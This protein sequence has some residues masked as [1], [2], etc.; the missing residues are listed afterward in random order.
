MFPLSELELDNDPC[1]VCNL[2]LEI[3]Q[4]SGAQL[5]FNCTST[6]LADVTVAEPFLQYRCTDFF[7]CFSTPRPLAAKWT[8]MLLLGTALLFCA[9]M[10]IEDKAVGLTR[11]QVAVNGLE[12]LGFVEKNARRV[13]TFRRVLRV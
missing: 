11:F 7:S 10:A 4:F 2:N 9:R 3:L 12:Y 6:G 5:Y 13:G 8:V 1:S